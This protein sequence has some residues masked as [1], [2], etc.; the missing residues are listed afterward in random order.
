MM[1]GVVSLMPASTQAGKCV[2]NDGVAH[3]RGHPL[4]LHRQAHDR[5][6]CTNAGVVCHTE[7]AVRACLICVSAFE[8]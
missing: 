2:Q 7:V 3:L 1:F 6:L 4:L 8:G 5:S